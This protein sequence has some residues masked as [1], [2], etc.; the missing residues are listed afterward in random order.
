MDKTMKFIL[1]RKCLFGDQYDLMKRL[2][3]YRKQR[4]ESTHL[5]SM[6]C[7]Y[8]GNQFSTSPL[9]VHPTEIRNTVNLMKEELR[10]VVRGEISNN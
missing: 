6:S 9:E 5:V 8:L 7:W 4:P 1:Y 2:T 10:E 3:R